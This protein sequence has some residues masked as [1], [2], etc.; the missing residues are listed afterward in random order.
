MTRTNVLTG[1]LAA[2]LVATSVGCMSGVDPAMGRA[3]NDYLANQLI[4][5]GQNMLAAGY[6]LR[7][8]GNVEEGDKLVQEGGKRIRQGQELRLKASVMN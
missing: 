3:G 1:L 6:K 5:D 8:E 2:A 7:D 4:S